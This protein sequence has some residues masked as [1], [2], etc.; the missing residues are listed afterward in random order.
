MKYKKGILAALD[1]EIS[2]EDKIAFELHKVLSDDSSTEK[3]S[4]RRDIQNV[5]RRE[6]IVAALHAI[7]QDQIDKLTDDDGSANIEL[8]D[9]TNPFSELSAAFRDLQHDVQRLNEGMEAERVARPVMRESIT[10][11]EIIPVDRKLRILW[12]VASELYGP[13]DKVLFK[14]Q[15]ALEEHAATILKSTQKSLKIGRSQLKS[16][17]SVTEQAFFYNFLNDC[18]QLS[19]ESG[20]Q[21]S[22][23]KLLLPALQALS[24]D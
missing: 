11:D 5:R 13:S 4:D 23:L 22:P 16:I 20:D 21:I 10:G 15:K 24:R 14:T 12:Y 2:L 7:L 18:R 17:G 3:Y 6:L 9:D 1:A 19:K 8:A